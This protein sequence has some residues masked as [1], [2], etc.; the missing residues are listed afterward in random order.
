MIRI[1]SFVK[2]SWD[3]FITE[4]TVGSMVVTSICQILGPER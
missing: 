1:E 3:P 2:V 4:V